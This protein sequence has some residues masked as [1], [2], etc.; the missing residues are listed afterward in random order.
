[1]LESRNC[2]IEAIVPG[3]EEKKLYELAQFKSSMI[4]FGVPMIYL[5]FNP[6]ENNSPIVLLYIG[7]NIDIESFSPALHC[8]REIEHD[9]GQSLGHD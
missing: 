7:K 2:Y 8:R 9:A 3:S 4:H 6:G 1:M 5:T